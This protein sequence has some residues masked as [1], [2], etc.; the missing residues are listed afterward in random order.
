MVGVEKTTPMAVAVE[1]PETVP[2]E[3]IVCICAETGEVSAEANKILIGSLFTSREIIPNMEKAANEE[4]P[5]SPI[6]SNVL[7]Y[8]TPKGGESSKNSRDGPFGLL[9]GTTKAAEMTKPTACPPCRRSWL[10]LPLWPAGAPAPMRPGPFPARSNPT[11]S[12]P[13]LP[14]PSGCAG[15][16]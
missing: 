9:V 14:R 12:D 2:V 10:F 15:C 8:S 6:I 11:P 13:E 3:E 5:E 16:S 7:R 1:A 4:S